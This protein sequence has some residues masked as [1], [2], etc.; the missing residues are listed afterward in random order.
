MASRLPALLALALPTSAGLAY[1]YFAGAPQRFILVNAVALAI[2]LLFAG[3]LR[4]PASM[5][6]RR[7]VIIVMLAAL[8]VPLVT[9]PSLDGV[10]RWLPIGPFQLHSGGLFLPAILALMT[11]HEKSMTPILLAC[12]LAGLLQPD[13]AI[14]F[15]IVF[16]AVGLHNVTRDGRIGLVCILGFGAALVM[17]VSG[18]PAPQEFVERVLVTAAGYSLP[19]ALALSLSLVVS[20]FLIF[21]SIPVAKSTRYALAGSLFGFTILSLMD[22]YPSVLVGY[23]AAPILGYGLGLGLAYGQGDNQGAI[24]KVSS[25]R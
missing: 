19:L 18:N 14:G 13:A 12:I 5:Q 6:V 15:G 2:G 16:A 4:A 1:L 25:P 10:N 8:F 11:R 21:R 22:D 24:D 23:G 17:A 7:L 9:G 3:F 20:F